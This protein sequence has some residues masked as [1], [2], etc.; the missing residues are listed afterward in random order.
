VLY[1]LKALGMSLYKSWAWNYVI[2]Y[3]WYKGNI[4]YIAMKRQ[5][6][7]YFHHMAVKQPQ[8]FVLKIHIP[9]L[10]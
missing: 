6:K 3:H 9:F 5:Q 8:V 1:T 2:H 10:F 7:M 4:N